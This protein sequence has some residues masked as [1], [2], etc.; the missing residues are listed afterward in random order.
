MRH[1]PNNMRRDNIENRG[2][3]SES[4]VE[5]ALECWKRSPRPDHGVPVIYGFIHAKPNDGLDRKQIDFVVKCEGN[6]IVP[7]QVK[8]SI[9]AKL[10]FER[11]CREAKRLIVA[12]AVEV[13]DTIGRVMWKIARGILWFRNKLAEQNDVSYAQKPT[14]IPE[15]KLKRLRRRRYCPRYSPVCMCH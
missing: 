5:K 8:S 4:M 3:H 1:A 10:K 15:V 13:K 6:L 14:P 7:V 9:R 2:V 12:I 11:Y